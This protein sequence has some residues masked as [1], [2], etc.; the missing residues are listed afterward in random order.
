[1]RLHC[2]PVF[3]TDLSISAVSYRCILKMARKISK[4]KFPFFR[5][6]FPRSPSTVTAAAVYV[7]PFVCATCSNP[8]GFVNVANV[9]VACCNTIYLGAV[10]A[11]S[12]TGMGYATKQKAKKY[13]L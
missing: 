8:I 11:S 7:S 2:D 10:G 6:L 3:S 1:M 4:I 12:E 13:D 5:F 9:S